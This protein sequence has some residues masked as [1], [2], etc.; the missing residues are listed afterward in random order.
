MGIRPF[1]YDF[2]PIHIIIPDQCRWEFDSFNGLTI[3]LK[4]LI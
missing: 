1:I 2:K 4:K 3:H